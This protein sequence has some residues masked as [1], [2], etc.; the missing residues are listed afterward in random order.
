MTKFHR[1]HIS[2]NIDEGNDE[3]VKLVSAD[4]LELGTHEITENT[5]GRYIIKY[6]VWIL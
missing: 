1:N 3:P 5:R 2:K 6:T 4:K